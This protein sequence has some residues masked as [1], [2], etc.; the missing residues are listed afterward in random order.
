[1]QRCSQ[2][3]HPACMPRRR[4]ARHIQHVL[5]DVPLLVALQR[6]LLHNRDN[7]ISTS[8]GLYKGLTSYADRR[9]RDTPARIVCFEKHT[10]LSIHS[11][12]HLLYHTLEKIRTS[13]ESLS[14]KDAGPVRP[15]SEPLCVSFLVG[16][17]QFRMP[18][19]YDA[20]KNPSDTAVSSSRSNFVEIKKQCQIC[21][22][23]QLYFNCTVFLFHQ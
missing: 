18:A 20:I 2:L 8:L 4:L 1:M 15:Q 13:S 21:I 10:N 23:S 14:R 16:P 9:V 22:V 17:I 11:K 19:Q 12:S 3:K 7:L 6:R 5:R